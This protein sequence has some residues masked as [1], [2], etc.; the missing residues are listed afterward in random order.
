[1]RFM[2]VNRLDTCFLHV[3]PFQVLQVQ[4]FTSSA[5]NSGS[6]YISVEDMI[7]FPFL[8]IP[9]L[10]TVQQDGFGPPS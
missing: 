2:T 10:S 4:V 8:D 1:M 5:W 3:E 7:E 6:G 9:D